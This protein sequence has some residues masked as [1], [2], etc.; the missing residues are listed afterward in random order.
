[1]PRKLK[2]TLWV[3]IGL[4]AAALAVIGSMTLVG[5]LL[6]MFLMIMFGSIFACGILVVC[7]TIVYWTKKTI[8]QVALKRHL[9]LAGASSHGH[10]LLPERC[11]SVQ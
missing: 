9:L 2:I 6:S 10:I 5:M 3:A 11:A 8:T 1:M 7:W 4:L